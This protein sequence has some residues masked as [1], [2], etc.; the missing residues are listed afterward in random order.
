[1]KKFPIRTLTPTIG[2]V[3]GREFIYV[4]NSQWE[5]FDAAGGRV[6]AKPL[7]APRLLVVP[8]P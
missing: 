7:T 5:K 8:L 6:V 4:A 2:A 3:V 1:M